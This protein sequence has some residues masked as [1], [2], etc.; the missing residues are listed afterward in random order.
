MID[1]S[2]LSK[3]VSDESVRSQGSSFSEEDPVPSTLSDLVYTFDKA[4][5][6]LG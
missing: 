5:I 6:Y 3:I 4:Y 2:S 1:L